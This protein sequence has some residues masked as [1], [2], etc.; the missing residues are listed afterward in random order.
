MA[1]RK[2]GQLLA[3]AGLSDAID[4]CVALLAETGD[5]VLTSDPDDLRTIC[6]AAGN[7]VRTLPGLD[8]RKN[9]FC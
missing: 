2:A 9:L 1:G 8:V 6:E 3:M 4:A 5:H 7:R